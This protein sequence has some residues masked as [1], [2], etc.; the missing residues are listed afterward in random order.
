MRVSPRRGA[1]RVS[2][3]SWT[4]RSTPCR[5]IG[6]RGWSAP[7]TS[8]RQ[9]SKLDPRKALGEVKPQSDIARMKADIEWLAAPAREGRGAGSR[10]LD[11]AGNYIAERFERLGL[12]PMTPGARGDD[13]YFQPFNITGEN[14]EQLAA[15]NVVGVLPGTNAALNGQAL[16]I[17]AHYDHLGFGWPDARAGAKG[18][19]HPGADDNA[20]AVP[21]LL[22]PAPPH[23]D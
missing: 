3:P 8:L 21:L 17:S 20:S 11:A 14:G 22:G 19:F 13:R 15:R 2:R 9:R 12:S 4:A 1:G 6:R 23:S 10:G 5:P 16:V 7:A 18:Q